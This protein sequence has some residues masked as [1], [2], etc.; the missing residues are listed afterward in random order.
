M[1]KNYFIILFVLTVSGCTFMKMQSS[2]PFTYDFKPIA[3][4]DKKKGDFYFNL[5]INILKNKGYEVTLN[6]VFLTG[7]TLPINIG[8]HRWRR[9]NDKWDLTYQVGFQVLESRSGQVFWRIIHKIMGTRPGKEPR[10][11]EPSDFDE[12]EKIFNVLHHDLAIV[13]SQ[14]A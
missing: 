5:G 9:N 7:T 14:M 6:E 4:N 13:F 11:F 2:D 3:I 1:I 8:K 10:S 12:T